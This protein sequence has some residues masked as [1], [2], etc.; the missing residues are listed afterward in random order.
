[1]KMKIESMYN[2][3]DGIHIAG[4]VPYSQREHVLDSAITAKDTI[5][6]KAE[7]LFRYT[8]NLKTANQ[9]YDAEISEYSRLHLGVAELTQ[10]EANCP[11]CST[12]LIATSRFVRKAEEE[13]G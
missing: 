5:K 2:C 3:T 8:E 10:E 12:A 1:M 4:L 6:E 13:D 7:K 11:Y 9:K